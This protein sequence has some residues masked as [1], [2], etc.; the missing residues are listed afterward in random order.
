MSEHM[1]Q[2]RAPV[3]IEGPLISTGM[4]RGPHTWVAIV[5][6]I[7][8]VVLGLVARSFTAPAFG[9]IFSA[10]A[11]GLIGEVPR[12]LRTG[13][14]RARR[15]YP[16]ATVRFLIFRREDSPIH[17]YFHVLT[18]FLL[19]AFSFIAA[20]FFFAQAITKHVG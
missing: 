14:V 15:K 3:A 12:L 16:S 17:F 18:Y 1:H 4:G 20:G 9:F 2:R 13:E 19:G 7:T 8:G 11:V 10:C 6:A 5:L